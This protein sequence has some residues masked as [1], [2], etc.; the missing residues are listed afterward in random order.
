MLVHNAPMTPEH[1]VPD[2]S[3]KSLQNQASLWPAAT[4]LAYIVMVTVNALA[5]ILPLFGRNTAEV[6]DRYPSLFTPAGYAFSIWGVIYL[7]LAAFIVYQALPAG[8]A[9][10]RLQP[11]RPLFV[12]SAAFN[13]LWLVSWHAL[14]IPV[15]Q[16]LMIALLLSLIALYVRGRLWRGPASAAQLLL[17]ELPFS[18]YLGWISV[19]A[20]AN[21]AIF[22]IDLGMDGGAAAPFFTVFV[23]VVATLLGIFGTSSRRDWAFALAIG[24][25]LAGIAVAQSG[26]VQRVSTAAVVCAGLL[27]VAASIA[28]FRGRG[29]KAA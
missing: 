11:M 2:D 26:G 23:I 9:N 3:V 20:I 14:W 28:M 27:V 22:F 6:S 8:R 10:P 13:A 29:T 18:I 12:I 17:V 24:W 7:L 21:T 5:N 1:A 25:G 4:I 16:A 19:A 15:S